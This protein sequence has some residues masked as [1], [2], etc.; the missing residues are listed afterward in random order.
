MASPFYTFIILYRN[1][2]QNYGRGSSLNYPISRRKKKVVEYNQ[3]HQGMDSL[4]YPIMP[5]FGAEAS[6]NG[7]GSAGAVGTYETDSSATSHNTDDLNTG[8]D[9]SAQGRADISIIL[10]QLMTITDQ[11]NLIQ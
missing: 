9:F 6:D 11:V 10:N 1:T 4:G 7:L 5:N 8:G 2:M 3:N